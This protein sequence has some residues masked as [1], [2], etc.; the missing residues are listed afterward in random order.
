MREGSGESPRF[1]V[2]GVDELLDD[3]A[4]FRRCLSE[5]AAVEPGERRALQAVYA[6]FL[7]RRLQLLTRLTGQ[8]AGIDLSMWQDD[9]E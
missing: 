2:P 4:Y 8:S 5:A 9:I 7:A 6:P 1:P 3:I